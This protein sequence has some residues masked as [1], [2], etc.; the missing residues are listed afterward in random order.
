MKRIILIFV[1]LWAGNLAQGQNQDS[2]NSQAN[3]F[4]ATNVDS[5][6]QVDYAGIK[7]QPQQLNQLVKLI[8]DTDLETLQADNL[9]AFE[10]NAYN[11][12]VIKGI[13]DRY[14]VESPL[15]I[16]GFF[17]GIKYSVGGNSL[18]L[19]AVSYTH[20]TLPTTSRV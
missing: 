13:I 11:L 14:P 18:T 17:D 20:L 6:G 12:L 15:T 19:N 3:Q 7:A 8:A 10:I 5:E 9:K 1:A 16:A 4:F 2:F